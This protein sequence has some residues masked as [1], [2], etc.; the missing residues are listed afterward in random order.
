[1]LMDNYLHARPTT[2]GERKSALSR[3]WCRALHVQPCSIL[4]YDIKPI[5][6]TSTIYAAQCCQV[7]IVSPNLAKLANFGPPRANFIFEFD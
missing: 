5:S 1:M 6:R 4:L 2:Y 3:L 7:A